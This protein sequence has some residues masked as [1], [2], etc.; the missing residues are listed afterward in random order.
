MFQNPQSVRHQC[1]PRSFSTKLAFQAG[2]L[3]LLGAVLSTGCVSNEQYKSEKAR[4]LNFQRLLAQEENRASTLDDK[5]AY[6]DK[7]INKLNAQLKEME[8]KIAASESENRDLTVK[9][10]ALKQQNHQ[11]SEPESIPESSTLSKDSDPS[12]E[13]T[14]SEPSLSDPF[15]SDEELTNMLDHRD[16]KE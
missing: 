7:E 2:L 9:L 6:K 5:L 3:V 11:P 12:G 13:K 15:L 10:D 1:A 8:D 16:I 14:L 4:C